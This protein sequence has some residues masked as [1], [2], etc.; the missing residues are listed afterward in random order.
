M[1]I[2]SS[3]L[4]D[5]FELY[6]VIIPGWITP[7]KP[8]GLAK[9][10]IPKSLYDGQPQGLQCLIDPWN[11][12]KRQSWTM[13]AYDRADLYVNDDPAAVDGK[14]VGIGE[15][16]DRIPLHIPHGQLI[17]GVN[18]LH[19]K[20]TRPG[21]NAAPSRDLHVLYHLRAPGEPAPEGLDLVIPP[22]VIND[23][24]SA[25]RAAQGVEFRFAY[26]NPRNYDRI[27]FL[28]G[29]VTVPFEVADASIPVVKTL[30]TDT[31]QQVGDNPNT[32]IQ[33]R[34]TDQ[35]G[36]S[37]QSP[38]KRL[39]IHLN[40]L[41]APEITSV[42][43]AKGVDVPDGTSTEETAVTLKGTGVSDKRVE[44]FDNLDSKGNA[45]VE[46]GIWTH[47]VIGLAT[48]HHSFTAKGIYGT[49]PVSRPW[50]FT[51][52]T[53]EIIDTTPHVFTKVIYT[54]SNFAPTNLYYDLERKPTGGT[55]PYTYRSSKPSVATVDVDEG[56]VLV[57]GAG[58]TTITVRD[59]AGKASSYDVT[60]SMVHEVILNNGNA[61]MDAWQ[62]NTWAA[63]YVQAGGF[64][65][66][67][68]WG[69]ALNTRFEIGSEWLYPTALIW[70]PPPFPPNGSWGFTSFL[71]D[72]VNVTDNATLFAGRAL[73]CMRVIG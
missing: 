65:P 58:T 33:Y 55:P 9:G 24:V 49:E 71:S 53:S 40:Q 15:E 67:L 17:H 63:P 7:V 16:Q 42:K 28:V 52:G 4:D 57:K 36:N 41:A 70:A 61:H 68:G 73:I 5:L 32:L 1:D 18:R 35:L 39:D 72:F 29:D 11:E 54:T 22:D 26:T 45:Y 10:G 8:A 66:E 3:T 21:E 23:G 59:S 37:N 51:V 30:F 56:G 25:E 64:R 34:V 6:P 38:T 12:L 62:A 14:T 43:D 44:I 60:A 46:G 69:S 47:A 2:Q 19:Y 31:F 20:V 48:G 50:T 13:A 27:S